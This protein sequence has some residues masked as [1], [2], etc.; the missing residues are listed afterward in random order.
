MLQFRAKLKRF[1]LNLH[2]VCFLKHNVKEFLK[3]KIYGHPV[4]ILSIGQQETAE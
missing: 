3:I 1:G 4:L 2:V